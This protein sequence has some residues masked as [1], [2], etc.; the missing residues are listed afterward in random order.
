V[1]AAGVDGKEP[2]EDAMPALVEPMPGP[3]PL[4]D[5]EPI[6]ISELPPAGVLADSPAPRRRTML[7]PTA[8]RSR[9]KAKDLRLL[10]GCTGGGD[11][12]GTTNCSSL[13]EEYSLATG[14]ST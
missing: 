10:E 13:S 14:A 12:G 5:A 2:D 1:F 8:L 7:M 4:L 3:A 6:G 9:T 11:V